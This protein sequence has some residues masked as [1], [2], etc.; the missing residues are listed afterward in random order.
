MARHGGTQMVPRS[1][2]VPEDVWQQAVELAAQRGES[3]ATIVRLALRAYVER[4]A[5]AERRNGR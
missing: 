1:I 5:A 4:H 3:V 2:K